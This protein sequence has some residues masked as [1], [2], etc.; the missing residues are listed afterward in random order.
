MEVETIEEDSL[1]HLDNTFQNINLNNEQSN[2]MKA[3]SDILL[4]SK[5]RILDFCPNIE[6]DKI[7]RSPL[8][9]MKK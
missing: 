5:K 8:K 2:S 4:L 3:I 1:T 6:D 7:F 9:K